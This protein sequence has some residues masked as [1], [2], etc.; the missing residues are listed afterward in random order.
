MASTFSPILKIELIGT[1]DQSGTWGSTTNVNLGTLI[2]QSIAA[3]ASI[4]VSSG[5]ITLTDYNGASDEARCMTLNVIGTPG[6]SRNI[7]T[8]TYTAPAYGGVAGKLYVVINGSDSAVVLK[9]ATSTGV[10][11]PSAEVYLLAYDAV[12][13]DYKL[14]GRSAS[15]S[16][17]ANTLVLRDGS[18]NFAAGAITATAFSGPL[19]GSVGAGTPSSGAFT[20]LTS[21]GNTTI[22][23]ASGDALTV[24]ATPTFNVPISAGS[25]GTGNYFYAVGDLLYAST[26]SALSKLADVATGNALIS[27]GV[28]V[29]PSYGKI[30]LTTHVSGT[31]PVANGGTGVTTS[32]GSGNVVLSTS[33]TLV[34]PI[35]GTPTSGNLAN[36][37][38]PTLN[39]NT[40]GNAATATLAAK[41]STLAAGGGNG[42][43]MTFN[44]SG[45]SGQPTWLWGG[46]DGS[47]MYVYN[48]SNFNVNYATSANYANS[49]GSAGTAGYITNSAYNGYGAR[50]ISTSGP[51]G[52]NSGDI[53][54]QY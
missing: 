6:V 44:W 35:L 7:I 19:N 24:N 4:D 31:L 34:T 17:I 42:T 43:A 41:A 2:E 13:A 29:A 20:T 1:G 9:T 12:D 5:N 45:Q 27:G 8:P 22:G 23:D 15:S 26:T 25:G 52:G 14:I 46:S 39:Q 10:S 30:G 40:T 28:G 48:P 53:W 36:C 3:A 18:G 16:N 37:T 32:T 21:S 51:S 33:P 50:T 38:F 54:Y 47:N 49:A 11:V